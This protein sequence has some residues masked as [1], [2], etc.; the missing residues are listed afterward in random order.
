MEDTD[1][2]RSTQ[3]CFQRHLQKQNEPK[4]EGITRVGMMTMLDDDVCD[5]SSIFCFTKITTKTEA[6]WT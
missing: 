2:V 4:G 1:K 3:L 6:K 5:G